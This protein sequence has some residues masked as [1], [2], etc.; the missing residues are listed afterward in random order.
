MTTLQPWTSQ[1]ISTVPRFCQ[2]VG[3]ETQSGF[4][5]HDVLDG[6]RIRPG[7]EVVDQLR[8]LVSEKSGVLE[9]R[10]ALHELPRY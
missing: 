8:A 6:R 2:G 7:I 10:G 3:P 1:G 4:G 9:L 5:T